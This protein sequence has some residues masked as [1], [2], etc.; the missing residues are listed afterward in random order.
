MDP[1]NKN[2]E[3]FNQKLIDFLFKR[4]IRKKIEKIDMNWYK[5]A[6]QSHELDAILNKW[7]S[8]GVTL[9]IFENDSKVILDSII[10]PPDQ[11]KQ[12]IGT[13][14]MQELT[15]YVDITGKRLELSPGQKDDYHGTTSRGRLVNF[16]KR[17]G[18]VENKG[19]NKDFTTNKTM[20]R[21]PNEL[22]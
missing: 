1:K 22:V 7:R 10:V 11:R 19:R 17:H 18:L 16:Y 9:D 20:Y 3:I 13:Q 6:Q 4:I 5:K 15:N 21:E 14:I 2:L 12:G 8:Q